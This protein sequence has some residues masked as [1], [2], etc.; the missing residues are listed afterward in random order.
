MA[1]T[2]AIDG[3]SRALLD[4]LARTDWTQLGQLVRE[5][6]PRIL[7]LAKAGPWISAERAAL[8]RLREAHQRAHAQVE[9]AGAQLQ[10]RLD[11]MAGNKEGW[12]AYALA[13]EPDTE[14]NNA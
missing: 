9:A 4:A 8:L 1:R 10:A 6:Q 13:G 5:L 3:L 2:H 11:E 12:M 14:Q 7:E